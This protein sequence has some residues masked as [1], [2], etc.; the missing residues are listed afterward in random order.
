MTSI[1]DLV[2]KKYC[3]ILVEKI[4]KLK[5]LII[6]NKIREYF[7]VLTLRFSRES[8]SNNMEFGRRVNKV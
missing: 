4:F 2:K 8:G 7:F 1:K 3:K 5:K 6:K